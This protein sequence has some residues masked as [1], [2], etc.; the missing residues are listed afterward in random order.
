MSGRVTHLKILFS[1]TFN[2]LL[3]TYLVYKTIVCLNMSSINM[4]TGFKI[5]MYLLNSEKRFNAL[6]RLT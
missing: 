4:A 2:C 6:P 1:K 5:G 3:T